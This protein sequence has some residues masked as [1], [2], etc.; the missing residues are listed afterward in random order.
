[1]GFHAQA[2][3]RGERKKSAEENVYLGLGSNLGDR[4][5][6]LR[7]ALRELRRRGIELVR[8]SSIYETEP[9]DHLKQPDFLNMAVQVRTSLEPVALLKACLGAEDALGRRR[10]V[11]KGPRNIDIDLLYYAEAVL[12]SDELTLPHP[13]LARRAFV[14]VPLAE[15]APD[16]RAPDSGRTV[17]EMLRACDDR[18]KVIRLG[19]AY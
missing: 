11:E 3:R 19:N 17:R 14:L 9:V 4:E 7:R 6:W 10:G 8:C 18:A 5:G 2:Q 1:M 13:R 16:F 15:I 12:Q